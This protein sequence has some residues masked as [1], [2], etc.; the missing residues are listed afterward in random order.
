MNFTLPLVMPWSDAQT[1]PRQLLAELVRT[2]S[3]SLDAA[4]VKKVQRKLAREL[5]LIGLETRF[6]RGDRRDLAPLLVA[7]LPGTE[8]LWVTL[9]CHAD[10]VH[11]KEDMPLE[12]V[13]LSETKSR[14]PGAIDNKGGIVVITEALKQLLE[15]NPEV[16]SRRLGVRVICSPSEEIGSPG[17]HHIFHHYSRSSAAVLGFEPANCR[18]HVIGSRQGNRW[19]DVKVQG[20]E[21]HAGRDH[22]KGLNAAHEIALKTVALESL[23]D[24]EQGLTVNVGHL[25]AGRDCHNIVAGGATARIDVR[26]RSLKQ[27]R[28]AHQKVE[29]IIE[30]TQV[31]TPEGQTT[32]AQYQVVDDCPPFQLGPKSERLFSVYREIVQRIEGRNIELTHAGGCADSNHFNREGMPVLD[33][34]GPIGD[35]MHTPEEWVDLESLETRGRA[36]AQLI[37]YLMHDKEIS[38]VP[39]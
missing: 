26:F 33:G 16:S 23:T 25:S 11:R 31:E 27:C 34:L 7:E 36:A 22:A 1:E 24:Y 28:E 14:G 38:H 39:W 15:L 10:T 8:D 6:F 5:E 9:V 12:L 35:K 17:L 29:K 21:A 32:K 2:S 4:G 19:Y 30:R 3:H 13:R 37:Q 18:G 20:R